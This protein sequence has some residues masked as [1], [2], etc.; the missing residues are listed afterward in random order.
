MLEVEEVEERFRVKSAGTT[1]TKFCGFEGQGQHE[2]QP[3]IQ[4][5]CENVSGVCQRR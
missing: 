2:S 4:F 3:V 5:H 1:G